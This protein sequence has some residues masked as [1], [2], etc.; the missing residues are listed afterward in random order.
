LLDGDK[1]GKSAA[2]RLVE[3]V[4]PLL[5]AG[6][7]LNIQILPEGM[8]PDTYI[9][10]SGNQIESLPSMPLNEYLWAMVEEIKKPKTPEDYAALEKTL[11]EYIGMIK[12]PS[13]RKYYKQ[14]CEK[15]TFYYTRSAS[16]NVRV[17][18]YKPKGAFMARHIRERIVLSALCLYPELLSK[19]DEKIANICWTQPDWSSMVECVLR[20]YVQHYPLT[21]YKILRILCR[22]CDV[23]D[24][25]L[26]YNDTLYTHAPYLFV[27]SDIADVSLA[28]EDIVQYLLQSDRNDFS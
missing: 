23:K 14:Y 25:R 22:E 2:Q 13:V 17:P 26:I 18:S 12:D 28:V 15:K 19:M 6:K 27:K 4:L 21:T 7:S 20:A 3:I 16:V 9:A 24:I 5:C 1:A 8:D 11:S 10:T